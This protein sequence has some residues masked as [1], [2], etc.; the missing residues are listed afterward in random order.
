ME[1]HKLET[2]E[3]IFNVVTPENIDNFLADFRAI[4]LSYMA[5]KALGGNKPIPM[6][7]GMTWTDDGV[8]EGK[9]TAYVEGKEDESIEFKVFK[10]DEE[11]E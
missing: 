6:K 4:L 8:V 11:S 3:D 10:K 5:V 2:V 1:S 7:D 9:V